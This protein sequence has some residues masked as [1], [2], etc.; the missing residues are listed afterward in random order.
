MTGRHVQAAQEP[1]GGS[2]SLPRAAAG[3]QSDDVVALVRRQVLAEQ[4]PL[5]RAGL[6]AAVQQ[7]GRVL[8]TR[9]ALA[10]V[11]RVRAELQGLG[12]LQPLADD[13]AV[14]DILVNAPDRIWVESD[15]GLRLAD[16]VLGSEADVR[17][18]AVRLVASGG[19]RLDDA[20]PCAD[21]QLG[22]YRVHA[23]LPP[24]STAGTVLSV[25]IRRSRMLLLQDLEAGGMMDGAG[26]AVLT[27]MIRRRLNYLISGAT[28]TGKTTLLA[29]L[30]SLCGADERLVLVEDAAELRPDHPHVL[31]LQ[32]RHGNI[33]GTG[34]V[35][36][37]ELVRQ[38]LRMR[39]D[40]LVVGECRGAEVREFL[41]AM[42]TGHSGAGGTL[43]ANSAEAV[44]ARLAALG[45]LAGMSRR[46]TDLQAA[47]A[48]DVLIHLSRIGP[49]RRITEIALIRAEAGELEVRPAMV[50]RNGRLRPAGAMT[51]L[52]VLLDA[53]A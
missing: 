44:P 31:G 20:N 32:S 33:E 23:V 25:R 49:E 53:D 10:A 30:L 41:A 3:P 11:D 24:V 8:G 39:P 14:T 52:N 40:R 13:P 19:R 7:S 22:A 18:L 9:G 6:A 2:P 16:V 26:S 36:Q 46:A 29:A 5:T 43:H 1:L 48:L 38:A 51:A 35:D 37:A 42:N 34:G 45:A 12:P 15:A 17:A 50:Y 47:S 4:S 21:V 27:A 28:G